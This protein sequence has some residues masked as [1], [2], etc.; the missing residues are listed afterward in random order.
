MKGSFIVLAFFAVGVLAGWGGLLPQ[1]VAKSDASLWM[2]YVML[3]SAGMGVGFDVKALSV[4]RQ[5]KLRI[6]L[7]PGAVAVGALVCSALAGLLLPGLGLSVPEAMAV[8]GGFGYYSLSSVIITKLGD[9]ALGSVALLAN[10]FRELVTLT[11][12]PL[13][14]RAMGPLAPLG[15][16]GATT[17]DT[18]LPVIARYCG[19]RYAVLAVF[20]GTCLTVLVPVLVPFLMALR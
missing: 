13:M 6:L 2:L 1:G 18:C 10:M 4:I 11:M 3:F 19:E 5:L 15:A 9:P 7:L 16:G 8:G 14:V 17:M 12:A 20:S